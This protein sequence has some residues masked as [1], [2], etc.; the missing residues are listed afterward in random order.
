MGIDTKCKVLSF[1][2]Q[3]NIGTQSSLN[4][5]SSSVHVHIQNKLYND[6]FAKLKDFTKGIHGM[7]DILEDAH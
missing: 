4:L 5:A 1:R 3:Q 6:Q 7:Q 2:K